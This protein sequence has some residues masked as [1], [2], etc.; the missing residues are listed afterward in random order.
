MESQIEQFIQYLATQKHYAGNTLMAYRN[1]L[2][3]LYQFVMNTRPYASSW[4]R[5]DTLLLQAYL[6]DLKAKAYSSASIAR[7]IAA[8]KSFYYYLTEMGVMVSNP[9]LQLEPPRVTKHP[10]RALNETQVTA[11]LNAP[12]E[13]SPKGLRDR[14]MLELMYATGVR[15]TELVMLDVRDVDLENGVLR[16]GKGKH[17]RRVPLSSRAQHALNEYLTRARNGYGAAPEQGPL[18]VNPRGQALT[19]QG[20]WLIMKQYVAQA[21]IGASVTPHSLRHSFAAHRLAQGSSLQD[22]QRMLGHAHLSTTQAYNRPQPA[23]LTDGLSHSS[24]EDQDL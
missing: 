2:L 13:P 24:S 16:I 23:A 4:A 12:A 22:V 19:R 10:P 17:E 7:K 11:L 3:Q 8:L 5:V 18:F 9:T 1:D 20:V 6:L 15:V 21:G 14:A